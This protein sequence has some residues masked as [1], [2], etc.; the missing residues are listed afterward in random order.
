[1]KV[2]VDS[3]VLL[4]VFTQ[5][6]LWARRSEEE[7]IVHAERDLLA[8]NPIIYAEVSVHFS[9]LEELDEVLS[10]LSSPRRPEARTIARFLHRRAR[11][12]RENGSVDARR[13]PLSYLFPFRAVDHS[14][15]RSFRSAR[16]DT[17]GESGSGFVRFRIHSATL[18]LYT[19]SE[20]STTRAVPLANVQRRGL[21]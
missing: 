1:M 9:T 16:G 7:L 2:L 13:L 21:Q 3:S 15:P 18:T 14:R 17:A 6:P 20:V 8:I 10:C 5:D 4:D 12:D 19:L 11:G